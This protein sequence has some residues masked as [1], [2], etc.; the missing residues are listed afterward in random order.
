MKKKFFIILLIVV[1]GSLLFNT[2]CQTIEEIIYDLTGT[3]LF[4]I[5]FTFGGFE[6]IQITCI[7]GVAYDDTYGD[8]GTYSQ[9][10]SNFTINIPWLSLAC[11]NSVDIYTGNFST[12]NRL[13]GNFSRQYALCAT[14]P[15]TFIADRI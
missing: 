7:G 11:G 15:G 3:W 8:V 14:D 10:G 5:S 12:V 9:T 1:F 4:D 13:T 2:S 6:T